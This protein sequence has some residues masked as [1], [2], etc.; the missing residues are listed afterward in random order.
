[1]IWEAVHIKT[2]RRHAEQ[3]ALLSR[4]LQG[5][6]RSSR[7]SDDETD[8]GSVTAQSKPGFK[9]NSV[10]WKN[11]GPPQLSAS[12]DQTKPPCPLSWNLTT[13]TTTFV[14]QKWPTGMFYSWAVCE[15]VWV[16]SSLL[17]TEKW[18]CFKKKQCAHYGVMP[19]L[20]EIYDSVFQ[21]V[22]RDFCP[23]HLNSL[24]QTGS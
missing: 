7:D 22:R 8:S 15:T 23:E 19:S 17:S 10:R 4:L 6:I 16:C 12:R 5:L 14:C 13:G 20:P 3:T 18:D 2:N 24:T 11:R 1:M 9:M 21:V